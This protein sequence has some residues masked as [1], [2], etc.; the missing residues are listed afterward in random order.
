MFLSTS[1]VRGPSASRAQ[2]RCHHPPPPT[3]DALE[4]RRLLAASPG[5]ASNA[6]PPPPPSSS[7]ELFTPSGDTIYFVAT[8]SYG[9]ELY[10]T[11]A[12]GGP[13]TRLTDVAPLCESSR[14]SQL[15]DVNGTLF[16]TATPSGTSKARDLWKTDGTPGGTVLVKQ[17][18]LEAQFEL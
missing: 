11:G 16:F 17:L 18:G 9:R 10:R 14:P 4:P 15:T 6:V 2:R 1:R 7:P 12:P 13:A 3:V 8:G 5:G